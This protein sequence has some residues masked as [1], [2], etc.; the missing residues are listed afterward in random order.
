[1]YMYMYIYIYMIQGMTQNFRPRTLSNYVCNVNQ[2]VWVPNFNP[3]PGIYIYIILNRLYV[4]IY[5]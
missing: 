3:D 1:M 5:I 4:Y 2:L